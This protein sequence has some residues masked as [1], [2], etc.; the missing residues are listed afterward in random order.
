STSSLTTSQPLKRKQLE[1]AERVKKRKNQ[2]NITTNDLIEILR[3]RGANIPGSD[4]KALAVGILQ[5]DYTKLT[6]VEFT[7]VLRAF[8]NPQNFITFNALTAG[9]RRDDWVAYLATSD[10]SVGVDIL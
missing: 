4:A 7:R 5:K 2:A 8:T 1:P 6:S 10:D 3:N 9:A